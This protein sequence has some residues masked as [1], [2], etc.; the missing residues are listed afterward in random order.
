MP[1]QGLFIHPP[2]PLVNGPPELA[3][4][5]MDISEKIVFPSIG[6][7]GHPPVEGLG[8]TP[9]LGGGNQAM[10]GEINR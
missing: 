8:K 4:V 1:L 2:P 5:K 3:V 6:Q 9:G 7:N 10:I